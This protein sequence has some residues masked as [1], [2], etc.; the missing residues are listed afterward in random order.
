MTFNEAMKNMMVE[1]GMFPQQADSVLLLAKDHALL[2]TMKGRMDEQ[3][4][5]Y[6]PIMLPVVW[7]SMQAIALEWIEANLPN[8]WYK[9][10]FQNN[11]PKPE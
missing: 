5:G 6:P 2:D 10:M 1:N 9:P 8:A 3:T 7:V 11:M 4:D